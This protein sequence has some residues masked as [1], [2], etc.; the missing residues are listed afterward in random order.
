MSD[1]L[2]MAELAA[3]SADF[4]EAGAI[5]IVDVVPVDD[6]AGSSTDQD[7]T[8]IVNGSFWTVSGDEA[9]EDQVK[10]KGKY[11]VEVAAGI[12][13]SPTA[14]IIYKGKS[15]AVKF[16]QP[17]GTFDPTRIIGLEDA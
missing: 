6:G 17:V 5:T 15:Y 1:D 16:P 3:I 9:G 11:R 7:T 13:V 8:R 14:R 2:D 10:V 12:I 4:M